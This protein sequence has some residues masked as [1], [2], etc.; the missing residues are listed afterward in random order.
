MRFDTPRLVNRSLLKLFIILWFCV[1]FHLLV[2]S[3][4][5]RGHE[6]SMQLMAAAPPIIPVVMLLYG[7]AGAAAFS[8]ALSLVVGLSWVL[9]VRRPRI[10]ARRLQARG[11]IVVYWV[12][13]W[14]ALGMSV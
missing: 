8:L 6:L 12:L 14:F 1:A 9:A 13:L 2:L 7:K 4:E 3:R 5:V 10:T 11:V